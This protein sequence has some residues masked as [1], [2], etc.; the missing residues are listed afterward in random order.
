MNDYFGEKSRQVEPSALTAFG[1]EISSRY[2]QA[3]ELIELMQFAKLAA[4]KKVAHYIK[5]AWYDS[6]SGCCTLE[7]DPSVQKGD[8][9]ASAV[10]DAAIE[11]IGYFDWFGSPEYGG[12]LVEQIYAPQKQ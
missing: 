6:K 9:V 7:L 12:A 1:I 11:S 2:A 10:Y 8:A 5:S 4:S 3:H